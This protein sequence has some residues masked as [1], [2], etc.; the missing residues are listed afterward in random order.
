M[1]F[2]IIKRHP[3]SSGGICW[4]NK[5]CSCRPKFR[6]LPP[7]KHGSVLKRNANPLCSEGQERKQ[8]TPLNLFPYKQ[9][10]S[11]GKRVYSEASPALTPRSDRKLRMLRSGL[12]AGPAPPARS[13]RAHKA[14]RLPAART[15]PGGSP[16]KPF[17]RRSP[18]AGGGTGSREPTGSPPGAHREPAVGAAPA[19]G[20]GGGSVVPPVA[21]EGG[22]AARLAAEGL[23]LEAPLLSWITVIALESLASIKKKKKYNPIYKDLLAVLAIRKYIS[24]FSIYSELAVFNLQNS[25]WERKL[26]EE[27]HFYKEFNQSTLNIFPTSPNKQQFSSSQ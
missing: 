23:G 14:S 26:G 15:P 7:G 16:S 10:A 21:R 24:Q 2:C 19:T 11:E 3:Q 1:V 20:E 5:H 25:H 27:K 4:S 6:V 9:T 8:F 13:S 17:R 18:A 12:S 22:R